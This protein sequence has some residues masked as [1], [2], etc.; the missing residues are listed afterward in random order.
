MHGNK[1]YDTEKNKK[2][3]KF[4]S[5]ISSQEI[6]WYAV[7]TVFVE[8]YV[9]V[10]HVPSKGFAPGMTWVLSLPTRKCTRSKKVCKLLCAEDIWV[11]WMM[12]RGSGEPTHKDVVWQV[13][14]RQ[15]SGSMQSTRPSDNV[16][17]VTHTLPLNNSLDTHLTKGT[18]HIHFNHRDIIHFQCCFKSQAWLLLE[19][20]STPLALLVGSLSVI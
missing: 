8:S 5:Q 18:K 2:I 6:I 7:V 13:A 20:I 19:N 4:M 17:Q 1:K 12:S 9:E 14:C 3:K 16:K 10:T 15:Q 11:S